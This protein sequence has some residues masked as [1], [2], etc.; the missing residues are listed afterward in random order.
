MKTN[1]SKLS[2]AILFS[3]LLLMQSHG[4]P[5]K[6]EKIVASISQI[7][8][9]ENSIGDNTTLILTIHSPN[10]LRGFQFLIV[11]N[12]NDRAATRQK[13]PVGSLQMLDLP[14]KTVKELEEQIDAHRSVEKTLDKGIHPTQI[15]QAFLLPSVHLPEV[16]ASL[17]EFIVGFRTAEQDS[18]E[19][20]ATTPGS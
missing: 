18:A 19:Q 20:S 10:R 16:S 11:T 12:S 5:E 6:H 13:F 8:H 14:S 7:L 4:N 9:A 3:I 15:S 1:I 17:A 2:I